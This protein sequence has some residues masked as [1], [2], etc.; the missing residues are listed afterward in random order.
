MCVCVCARVLR[1]TVNSNTT[2][3]YSSVNSSTCF[4]LRLSTGRTTI[5]QHV[6]SDTVFVCF[7]YQSYT[8]L[9]PYIILY[10]WST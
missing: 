9:T 2:I 6:N 8:A 7:G 3:V 4:G 10:S 5:K 1:I